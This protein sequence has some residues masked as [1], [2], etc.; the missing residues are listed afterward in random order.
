MGNYK[1]NLIHMYRIWLRVHPTWH[2]TAALFGLVCGVALA[3][4]GYEPVLLWG[5]VGVVLIGAALRWPRAGCIVLACVGGM[6]IGVVRGGVE[7]TARSSYSELVGRQ[8]RLQGVVADDID[9]A[10]AGSVRVQLRDIHM[11]GHALPG[12]VWVTA[13][14]GSQLMRGDAVTV[15]GVIQ[16][17]FGGFAATMPTGAV[18][19]V[20]HSST[21]GQVLAV[22]DGFAVAVRSEVAEPQASL[23]LGFLLGQ[24]SALSSALTEAMKITGLTHIVVASGYNLTILV[25]AARRLFENISKYLSTVTAVAMIVGFMA[26]T[27]LSPSMMRAGLVSLLSLWAWYFGRRFH[28]AMLLSLAAAVTVCINPSYVWGDLGW[29]LSFAAFA[30]VMIVA[31]LVTAYFYGATKPPFLVQVLIETIAATIIT[32]PIIIMTFGQLSIVSPLANLLVLPLIPA[33]MILSAMAGIGGLLHVG[34]WIGWPAEQLLSGIIHLVEWC[35]RFDWAQLT[36]HW[37]GWQLG[38][39]ITMLVAACLYLKW[40]TRLNLYT[41]NIVE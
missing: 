8:V 11:H 15:R 32:A 25:R 31:P 10:K 37:Q 29:L 34:H 6:I 5:V 27:G 4:L 14:E 18:E 17:G 22:R 3:G 35:A 30:G 1:E 41:A 9:S 36:V 23:G 16:P 33:A 24:K 12:T 21:E 20:Q 38:I 39:Y 19:T 7:Q 13:R 26:I 2:V 28:P 40:R